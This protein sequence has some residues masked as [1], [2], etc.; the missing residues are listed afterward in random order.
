V[1]GVCIGRFLHNIQVREVGGF[2]FEIREN[3]VYY[4]MLSSEIKSLA[5]GDQRE[6][7]FH[8]QQDGR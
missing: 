5:T 3:L 6:K 2:E 1:I 7:R 4:N 8:P